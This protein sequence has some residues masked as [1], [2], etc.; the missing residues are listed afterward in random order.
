[1]SAVTSNREIEQGEKATFFVESGAV[2]QRLRSSISEMLRALPSR[3]RTTRDLQKVFGVDVKLCWQVLK[4]S[5][6]GDALS[7]APF[8][9]TPGPMR[10]FLTA[11]S[12]AGVDA[13][14]VD[15]IRSAYGAFEE[16]VT[17]HAGD[18]TTF[19]SMATGAAGVHDGSNEDLQKAAIRLRKSAFQTASHYA[20]VQLDTYLGLSFVSP[21][22]TPGLLD[23]A[24]L[25]VKMGIRRLRATSNLIVD[26]TKHVNSDTS[27]ERQTDTL[28]R[29]YFDEQSAARFGAPILPRF[30][31]NPLPQFKTVIDTDGRTSIRIVGENV[32]QTSAVDLV[33]GQSVFNA[34]HTSLS[35]HGGK[36]LGFGSSID[37][38]TPT[39]V[40]ILD[41]LVHRP[42]FPHLDY[43]FTVDWVNNAAFPSSPEY[44]SALPFGERVIKLEAGV[45]GARTHEV[46][47]YIEMVEFVCDHCKWKMEDFDVYRVRLE[48]PLHH[49]RLWTKF[50]VAGNA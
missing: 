18:R 28:R 10:R 34:P 44:P 2:M 19:E 16:Q 17:I 15:R 25:R 11:A 23:A 7:L 8:V 13:Q 41:K 26:Q 12:S 50:A 40:V 48:Y 22:T 9:P 36:R 45:D 4:L 21:S 20:G 39:V 38:T 30:S 5:G 24:N 29:E 27:I 37:I 32:G 42:T 1:M 43:E 46:P 3:V 49:T 47:Q 33:F 31:S 6:P 14:V 35:M